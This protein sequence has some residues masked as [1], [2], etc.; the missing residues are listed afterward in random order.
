MST[1][2]AQVNKPTIVFVHGAF[3]ESS[4]WNGVLTRRCCINKSIKIKAF[5]QGSITKKL[6]LR[7]F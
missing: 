6:I 3:A 4:S 2:N 5:R 7:S 1:A